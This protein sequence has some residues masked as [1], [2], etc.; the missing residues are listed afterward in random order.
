MITEKSLMTN[1]EQYALNAISND[2]YSDKQ[3][4]DNWDKITFLRDTFEAEYNHGIH[5]YGYRRAM[6]EWIAGLPSSFNVAFTY[7]DILDLGK[8]WGHLNEDTTE[9]QEDEYIS[10]WFQNVANAMVRLIGNY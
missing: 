2:G 8:K 7:C 6:A 3:L 4:K 10:N 1:F 5:R 9:N